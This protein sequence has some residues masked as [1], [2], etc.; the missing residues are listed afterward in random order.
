M[1]NLNEEQDKQVYMEL[2]FQECRGILKSLA[3]KYKKIYNNDIEE[4]FAEASLWLMELY[5]T[6]DRNKATLQTYV[7]SCIERKFINAGKKKFKETQF[8]SAA[9]ID[10]L[11][12][13]GLLIY[14]N[15]VEVAGEK[16]TEGQRERYEIYFKYYPHIGYL[17]EREQD[18]F[19]LFYY[20]H[21]NIKD[22]AEQMD[23]SE[24]RIKELKS[25][26]IKKMQEFSENY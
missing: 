14:C 12:Q 22:I 20:N 11:D 10:E 16:M 15:D 5:D 18:I 9:S 13:E 17:P 25:K 19:K 24:I 7:Y 8:V 6:F 26:I 3:I 2:C 21:W 4:A 23:L 1:N